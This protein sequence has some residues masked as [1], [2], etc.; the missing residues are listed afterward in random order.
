MRTHEAES[1]GLEPRF[2]LAAPLWL[3]WAAFAVFLTVRPFLWHLDYFAQTGPYLRPAILATLTIIG[4]V[5]LWMGVL[6]HEGSTLLVVANS[7]RLLA[8]ADPG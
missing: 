5:P 7:L 4:S 6:G 3:V 8:V 2:A 1:D